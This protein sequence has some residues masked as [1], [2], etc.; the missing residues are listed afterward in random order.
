MFSSN[1]ERRQE[2]ILDEIEDAPDKEY[3][4]K[5]RSVRNSRSSI[6]HVPLLRDYYTNEDE[7]MICQI[8]KEEMPFKKR[9]GDYYFEAVEILG[10]NE[11]EKEVDTNYLALCPVCAAMFKEFIKKDDNAYDIFLN[12]L[13]HSNSAEIPVILGKLVTDIRFVDKHFNDLKTIIQYLK[14]NTH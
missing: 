14:N 5:Q 12:E 3:V 2:K 1:P 6:D 7:K 10:I 4:H 11:C 8:C 13:E 9:N